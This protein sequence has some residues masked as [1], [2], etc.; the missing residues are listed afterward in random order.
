MTP[1]KAKQDF[2]DF[3]YEKQRA[4]E[5]FKKVHEGQYRMRC[6][7]CGDT[8]KNMNE[9]HLYLKIDLDTDYNIAYNCFK[10]GESSAFITE[11]LLNLIGC[12]AKLKD[13][14]LNMK[15]S[16]RSYKKESLIMNFDYKIPD[17][18]I[19][20]NKLNYISD[21]LGLSFTDEEYKNMK[22]ITSLYDFLATNQIKERPFNN[23]VLNI[24]QRDYVGFL[25]NGNSHILFRDVTNKNKLSW[26]KYP[27][28]KDSRLNKVFYTIKQDPIDIFTEEDITINL[29]EGVLDCLGVANHF[30]YMGTN[31]MNIA[32]GSN[33][34]SGIILFLIKLG[35]V[36]DNIIIN[37]FADNDEMFNKDKKRKNK[38][39]P[40]SFSFL[41]ANL[42]KY[43]PLFKKINLY[44]NIKQK[45]YGIEK[46]DI[47]LKKETM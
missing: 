17:I 36:G 27:I 44:H 7:F 3:L 42:K 26:I 25:T 24:L 38:V 1:M 22:I 23:Y 34:Y 4:G 18:H 19:M 14:L 2:V 40:S 5:Y 41:K 15:K 35:L 33:R 21:R 32:V 9:G 10:C 6:P 31:T 30:N 29:S 11:E 47:I 43:R 12:D 39:Y 13:E 45:D 46:K 28:T 37:I 20:P 8:Q 16:S